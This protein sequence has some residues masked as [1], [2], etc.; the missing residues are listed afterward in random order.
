MPNRFPLSSKLALLAFSLS[1]LPLTTSALRQEAAAPLP[2]TTRNPVKP[3]AE[4][5]AHAKKVYGYECEM[6]H[7]ATGDGKTDLAKDMKLTLTDLTDPKTLA[8]KSDA[9]I[10]NLI[11]DGK[12][13]MTPE[14]GRMKTDD[15]WNLVLYVRSMAKGH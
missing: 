6:C 3:T 12:G 7:G 10:F 8:D 11:R 9:D 13:P 1:A 4:S 2:S 14:G 5:Q 15:I